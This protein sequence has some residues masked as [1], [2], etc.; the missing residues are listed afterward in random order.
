[1]GKKFLRSTGEISLLGKKSG[2]S[3]KVISIHLSKFLMANNE[4]LRRC[5]LHL[6]NGKAELQKKLDD[7]RRIIFT[8]EELVNWLYKIKEDAIVETELILVDYSSSLMDEKNIDF[9]R[10]GFLAGIYEEAERYLSIMVA[11]DPLDQGKPHHLILDR[12]EKLDQ[13]YIDDDNIPSYYCIHSDIRIQKQKYEI[14]N[15]DKFWSDY[16]NLKNKYEVHES[17]GNRRYLL[18]QYHYQFKWELVKIRPR[19]SIK[20]FLDFHKKNYNGEEV[21]FLNHIEFRVMPNLDGVAGSNYPIYELILKDWLKEKRNKLNYANEEFLLDSIVSVSSSFLDNIFEYRKM[22]DE[23]KFN[24]LFCGF[25]NQRLSHKKWYAKDQSLG[26]S[27]NSKSMAKRAGIAFRDLI[28]INENHH[29]ISAIEFFR[30]KYVSTVS[31]KR[32]Q[33]SDHLVKIFQNEPL[34]ISPLFI[35][36]YCETKSFAKSWEKY[37]DY[38]NHINFA[39]YGLIEVKREIE[40]KPI[41]SNIK[42]AHSKHIRETNEIIVFHIF[43]NMHP[44]K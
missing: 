9:E 14:P 20:D 11:I 36:I 4:Y 28:L 27:S 1:M 26:G 35:I 2:K 22:E 37:L 31:A 40:L 34:G 8:R 3:M 13:K 21:D 16:L 33:I 18:D 38:L 15:L 39:T 43:I 19:E 42:V 32:S 10:A 12:L 5:L 6:D 44:D 17:F 23:N 41:R 25:L 30:L 29:H 7:V 24:T